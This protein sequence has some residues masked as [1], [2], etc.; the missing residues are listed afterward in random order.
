MTSIPPFAIP[1]PEQVDPGWTAATIGTGWQWQLTEHQIDELS[2]AGASVDIGDA[3]SIAELH[4]NPPLLPS[5]TEQIRDLR[6][7]LIDGRGLELIR[8]L[9]V[10]EIGTDVATGAML[11]LSGH[12]GALRRQ[13]AAGDLIGHVRNTGA[14]S[15]DPAVRLYQTAERQTFHTDSTDVVGLLALSVAREG[16]DSLVVSAQAAYHA[17]ASRHPELVD[18]LFAAV[19]TDRRGEVP[20]GA[21]P[22]FNIPVFTWWSNALTVMYQ[23]QYIDSASRFEGAPARSAAQVAALNAFDD[24]CN[25]PA[26]QARMTLEVG[27]M[28]FVHNHSVLHDRTGFVDDPERPRHLIRTWMSVPEDRPLH[29]IFAERFSTVTPG[30][31]GGV[32]AV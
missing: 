26:L 20:P 6:R 25:D 17:V 5:L 10:A 27:D 21:D 12:L 29:P 15:N 2:T 3:A 1:R 4:H 18:E 9:P 19:A 8:G 13:N 31:R 22:W 24:A 30:E 16:G 28:Q 7:N 32:A 23:R 14:R 11:T